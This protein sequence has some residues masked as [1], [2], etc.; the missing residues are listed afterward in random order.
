MSQASEVQLDQFNQQLRSSQFYQDWIKAHGIQ[1]GPGQG[2]SKDQRKAF[3]RDLEAIGVNF[4]GL[5]IDP[6]GNLNQPTGV[7]HALKK[8]GPIVGGAALLAFGIPGF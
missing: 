5:E 7:G 8:Y 2:F 4:Q 1:F 6:A 3:Q